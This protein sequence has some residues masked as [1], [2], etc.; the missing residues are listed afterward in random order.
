MKNWQE[1]SIDVLEVTDGMKKDLR[2]RFAFETL[3]DLAGAWALNRFQFVRS[4]FGEG[5]T[6][7]LIACVRDVSGGQACK[8]DP[9]PPPP[10]VPQPQPQA[11]LVGAAT[12]PDGGSPGQ[13][14]PADTLVVPVEELTKLRA[15]SEALASLADL[16]REYIKQKEDYHHK[17]DQALAAKK[18]MDST[19]AELSNRI[20]DAVAGQR[21]LPLEGDNV[22]G[23]DAADPPPRRGKK[24]RS[25]GD[26][27]LD[28]RLPDAPPPG[29]VMDGPDGWRAVPLDVLCQSGAKINLISRLEKAGIKTI[30]A[31]QHMRA[32]KN[33]PPRFGDESRDHL[34][35]IADNWLMKNRDSK[36]FAQAAA[37]SAEREVEFPKLIVIRQPLTDTSGRVVHVAGKVCDAVKF[38]EK[39]SADLAIGVLVLGSAVQLDPDQWSPAP[40]TVLRPKLVR[41]LIDVPGGD[42]DVKG[43]RK[44]AELVVTQYVGAN[45]RVRARDGAEELIQRNEFEVVEAEPTPVAAG[46]VLQ[47]GEFGA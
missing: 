14:L 20:A 22:P 39:G 35:E 9:P 44:G 31:F 33:W 13:V 40:P 21:R 23:A 26:V 32:E 3:A 12:G 43:L 34:I 11:E 17:K 18:T 7:A 6:N 24:K 16:N 47:A 27:P 37:A 4:H 41:L 1:Q 2:E 36:E 30:G 45:V 42:D 38:D 28:D 46:M 8:D 25:E 19:A 5:G 10:P 29:P 15:D